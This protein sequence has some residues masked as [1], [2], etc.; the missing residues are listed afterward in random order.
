MPV[1]FTSSNTKKRKQMKFKSAA[2]K[3]AYEEALNSEY[4]IAKKRDKKIQSYTSPLD[5]K[6]YVR[7]TE[8]IPSR[9]N[10]IGVALKQEEKTYT[11]SNM[12]GIGTLH[13]SNAVPVFCND[14]AKAM[15]SMR[16]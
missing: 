2:E 4:G 3:R 1:Y 5:S 14:E 12:I 7:E 8:Y 9:G 16:R 6:P 10:G 15:A 11:G 13:K